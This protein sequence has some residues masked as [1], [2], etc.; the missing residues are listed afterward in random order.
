MG[1]LLG[2]IKGDTRSLDYRS[3]RDNGKEHGNKRI[4]RDY[5]PYITSISCFP[6][7]F[8]LSQF[9]PSS[10]WRLTLIKRT[11]LTKLGSATLTVFY[12]PLCF[13]TATLW[14]V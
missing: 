1:L 13:A 5:N 12:C 8:P 7:P 9:N 4:Y 3:Y 11:P 14:G 2:V 10:P 6:F